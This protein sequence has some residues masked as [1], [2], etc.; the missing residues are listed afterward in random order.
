[1]RVAIIGSGPSLSTED[2]EAIRQAG[3]FTI[4][5]NSAWKYAR[6]CNV[7]FAGDGS[8]WDKN[9]AEIDI[10]AERW[11]CRDQG[12]LFGTYYFRGMGSWNSGANAILLAVNRFKAS[13]IIL[14][15]FD[16]S[17]VHGVHVHGPHLHNKNPKQAD[18]VR[19][20]SE[21]AR[22]A[23]I[24]KT[25]GVPLVNCS[26]YTEINSIPRESLQRVLYGR[27][28]DSADRGDRGSTG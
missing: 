20:H 11:S 19:W 9:V 21:F 22:A 10:P 13:S 6:F 23:A 26:R 14:T 16:C 15:G 12:Q 27:C 18:I 2:T 25:A 17:L 8:W 28:A 7:L 3:L 5:V 24:A 4:A 1:M